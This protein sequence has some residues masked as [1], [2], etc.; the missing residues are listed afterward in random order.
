MPT[1]PSKVGALQTLDPPSGNTVV[2]RGL[3]RW[4]DIRLGTEMAGLT[5]YLRYCAA[6]G[7]CLIIRAGNISVGLRLCTFRSFFNQFRIAAQFW[8]TI[9]GISIK[10]VNVNEDA[11][12]IVYNGTEVWRLWHSRR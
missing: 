12:A 2:W 10:A 8:M 1:V 3:S 6:F 9:A 4:I 7:S 11:F 5:G